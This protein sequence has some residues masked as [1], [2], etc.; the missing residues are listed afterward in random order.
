LT[1]VPPRRP[2]HP[3][4]AG[5]P[6]LIAHRGGAGLAPENTMAAFRSAVD[7]WGA[8]MLE[9][10]VHASR[11]GKVVVIHDPTVDRTTDGIG[12]VEE[13]PWSELSRLDAGYHFK[14]TAGRHPFRGAGVRLP[15]LDELL[16]TFPFMRLNVEA[17]VPGVGALLFE[18]IRRHRAEHRVLIAAE[19]EVARAD[20]PHYS[21]PWGASRV[22]LR[23]F[24]LAQRLGP[25]GRIYTPRADAL[26]IPDVWEGRQIASPGFVREAHRRNLPV[27]VWTVDE[28]A[29][30]RRLLDWG[31]DG[32]QSDRPDLLAQVLHEMAGRPLPRGF[33]PSSNDAA[34]EPGSD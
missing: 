25:F 31:V 9:L 20:I 6:L 10:D 12:R 33:G 23:R 5:A 19:D 13:L 34:Q 4:F 32:I 22:Q 21:G 8:D 11:D 2:G 28:P 30:M 24:F 15:L 17:K 1:T 3:Y 26:Q 14:D 29:D 16:E 18:A 27:H 7:D